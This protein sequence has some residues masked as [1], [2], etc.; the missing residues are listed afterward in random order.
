M[1]HLLKPLLL[2]CTALFLSGAVSAADPEWYFFQRE[3]G[4]MR[5]SEAPDKGYRWLAVPPE[6]KTPMDV[7]AYM[8]KSQIPD[9]QITPLVDYG[10]AKKPWESSTAGGGRSPLNKTNAFVIS[11]KDNSKEVIVMSH[12]LCQAYYG[13]SKP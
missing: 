4:C 11:P 6:V 8:R 1:Q 10:P 12:E 9:A 13:L 7:L 3:D 5:F 2:A